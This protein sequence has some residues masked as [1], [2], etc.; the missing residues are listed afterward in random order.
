[1]PKN[2]MLQLSNSSTIRYAQLFDI[3]KTVEVFCNR[4]TSGIDGC[5]STAIGA[6]N[7]SK[8][9]TILIAGDIGFLYD[10]NALWNNYIPNDFKIILLNNGGGGIFRILPGHDETPVFNT[11]FETSHCLT[12]E[13]LAKMYG[14][15]YA[16]ASSE[17]TLKKQLKHFYDLEKPSILEV[18]TPTKV[19]NEYLLDYFKHLT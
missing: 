11:F 18:F 13:Q 16:I 19:N 9:Q 3:D 7:G 8:K 4:G 2:T 5:T 12:A 1:M 15:E 17:E 6:A 10:S 14:F